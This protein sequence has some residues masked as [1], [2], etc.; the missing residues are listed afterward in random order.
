MLRDFDLNT[1][2]IMLPV[3]LFSISIH[4]FCHA[5]A[6]KLL[7]DRT[8]EMLG[9]LTI[10]PLKH[11]DPV[12]TLMLLFAGFGWAKPVPVNSRSFKHPRRDMVIVSIAG[13]VGNLITAFVFSRIMRFI[14][15][16]MFSVLGN[17]GIR[18]FSYMIMI[19]IS[20]AAFNLLPI[21]PLDGSKILYG[22]IPFKWLRFYYMLEQYGF[23]ILLVLV[24]TRTIGTILWPIIS[25][26]NI[27]VGY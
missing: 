2:I 5:Y 7:G 9:R 3:V 15:L 25:F 26:F 14:P 6:A 11:I 27:L 13:I 19:N 17:A 18:F 23:I 20:L 1:I 4:E 12:G 16:S 10:N 24:L 8:A 22:F 21:P